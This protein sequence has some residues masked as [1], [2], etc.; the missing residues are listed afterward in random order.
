MSYYRIHIATVERFHGVYRV[1]QM[2]LDSLICKNIWGIE[3]RE[4]I[5]HDAIFGGPEMKRNNGKGY[6]VKWCCSHETL[7]HA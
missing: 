1:H 6:C 7:S 5:V 3:I 4:S 2:P